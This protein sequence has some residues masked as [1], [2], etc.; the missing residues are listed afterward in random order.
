MNNI[1]QVYAYEFRRRMMMSGL[2][3]ALHRQ[4]YAPNDGGAGEG[5]TPPTPPIPPVPP[6]PGYTSG[7]M[8]NG[9]HA[10][11]MLEAMTILNASESD[12]NTMLLL[13]DIDLDETDYGID[14]PTI[15]KNVVIDLQGHCIKSNTTFSKE[16]PYTKTGDRLF[17]V[18]STEEIDGIAVTIKNGTVKA[19]VPSSG[20]NTGFI[21]AKTSKAVVLEDLT[22]DWDL[23]ALDW[24]ASGK[25]HNYDFRVDV[26]GLM[27]N[28]AALTNVKCNVVGH[29]WQ[30]C[31]EA[32]PYSNDAAQSCEFTLDNCEFSQK[33]VDETSSAYNRGSRCGAVFAGSNATLTI[34]GGK[35]ISDNGYCTLGSFYSGGNI[36]IDN[37]AVIE[38]KSSMGYEIGPCFRNETGWEAV[39]QFTINDVVAKQSSDLMLI[40]NH[41]GGGIATPAAIWTINGGDF[42]AFSAPGNDSY[43]STTING[44]T[45][46]VDV[47]NWL[48][49]GKTCTY[50]SETGKYVVS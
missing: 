41:Q 28:G 13:D 11:T 23:T 46:N 47:S 39:S 32:Q 33:S 20:I 36:V 27:S 34:N 9:Q 3:S 42:S 12:F 19:T 8:V 17:R 22:I 29:D 49:A 25:E 37:G 45:F 26:I 7:F 6:T 48:G 38:S 24:E 30:G 15:Q 40:W 1:S 31:L 44:G 16:G 50:D 14:I 2:Y 10:E 18:Q 35:Y 43:R 5:P 21:Y 4:A